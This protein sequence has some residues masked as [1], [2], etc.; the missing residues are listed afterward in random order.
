[1]LNKLLTIDPGV[2]TGIA[3]GWYNEYH[4]YERTHFWLVK[5]GVQGFLHWYYAEA[6]NEVYAAEWVSEA[7]VLS[8]G[9]D[10]VA[11]LESVRIEGAMAALGLHPTYQFRTDKALCK[12][13]VLKQNGLWV[14]GKQCGHTD[15]RDVNDATIHAL[16]RMKKLKH[17][18]S[19]AHYWGGP[20]QDQIEP[21]LH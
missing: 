16:A 4:P 7:F 8:S 20:P 19:L 17:R 1:M 18:P 5:G 12:D 10:F 2:A 13:E 11:N 21:E 9:N 15:G 14:T 3:L 6:P